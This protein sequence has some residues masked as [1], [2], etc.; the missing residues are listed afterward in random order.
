MNPS[1]RDNTEKS[2]PNVDWMTDY[3]E[4]SLIPSADD[5]GRLFATPRPYFQLRF[6]V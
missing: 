6:K 2:F 5:L 1:M 4:I 3:Q